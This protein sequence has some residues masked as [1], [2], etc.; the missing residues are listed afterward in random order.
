MTSVPKEEL[1]QRLQMS[2]VKEERSYPV[3]KPSTGYLLSFPFSL[4]SF[5]SLFL[6]KCKN[7]PLKRCCWVPVCMG[8]AI[9]RDAL[10]GICTS[11]LSAASRLRCSCVQSLSSCSS[12]LVVQ[13]STT[14]RAPSSQPCACCGQHGPIAL[15][16]PCRCSWVRL[17]G[18]RTTF[19]Y[20][21]SNTPPNYHSSD[22]ATVLSAVLVVHSGKWYHLLLKA[23]IFFSV[24]L[25]SVAFRGPSMWLLS[26]LITALG[27]YSVV[28]ATER[29]KGGGMGWWRGKDFCGN[30]HLKLALSI[31]SPCSP[32]V[33]KHFSSSFCLIRMN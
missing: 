18:Q 19:P 6:T 25:F 31:I 26:L 24:I 13:G 27:D 10:C 12:T 16:I 22:P 7:S 1:F 14:T 4:L 8:E 15:S 17:G 29:E 2:L 11:A 9:P 32:I 5:S 23:G 28:L 30:L 20:H 3:C 33:Y 21:F